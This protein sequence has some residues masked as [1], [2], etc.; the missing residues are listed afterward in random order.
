[1]SCRELV[2]LVSAYFDGVLPDDV[3]AA[4]EQ[5]VRLC[6]SCELYLAQMRATIRLAHDSRQLEEQ[7]EVAALLAEFRD[8]KP[9]REL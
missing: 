9:G 7:P 2:E 4:F 8:W 5:H 6:P 3:R 1:M